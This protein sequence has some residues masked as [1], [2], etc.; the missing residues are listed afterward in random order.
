M[1]FLQT[2]SCAALFYAIRQFYAIGISSWAGLTPMV[3][4]RSYGVACELARKGYP[5]ASGTLLQGAKAWPWFSY[6]LKV[7]NVYARSHSSCG[8]KPSISDYTIHGKYPLCHIFTVAERQVACWYFPSMIAHCY[9]PLIVHLS[10]AGKKIKCFCFWISKIFVT[11][12]LWKVAGRS[13]GT[14]YRRACGLSLAQATTS[15]KQEKHLQWNLC[16]RKVTTNS[17]PNLMNW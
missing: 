13:W 4:D 15:L 1:F 8:N 11:L 5:I 14:R 9:L 16:Q 12:H 7:V 3:C 10:E 17:Y 2:N 6:H